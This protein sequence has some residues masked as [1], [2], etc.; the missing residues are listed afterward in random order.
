VII[1]IIVLAAV[2]VLI[3]TRKI[4]N[5]KL[6]IWQIMLFG[7]IVVLA[8]GQISPMNALLSINPDVIL[9]LF[10]MFVVGEALVESGYLYNLSNRYS[11]VPNQQIN[12]C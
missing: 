11:S 3:A 8:T 12:S 5:I 9:F 2:F 10:G 7:A 1:P 6:Q 4:G